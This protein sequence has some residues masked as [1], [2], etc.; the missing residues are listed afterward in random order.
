MR[1]QYSVGEGNHISVGGCR[2][3]HSVLHSSNRIPFQKSTKQNQAMKRNF[4][5]AL[6]I[7]QADQ[8]ELKDERHTCGHIASD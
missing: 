7:P 2:H 8:L 4:F 1:D 6:D 3:Y 5:S